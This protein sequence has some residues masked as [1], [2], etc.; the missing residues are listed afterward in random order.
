MWRWVAA[1]LLLLA[2]AV[3]VFRAPL[4][5]VLWPDMRVQRLLDEAGQALAQG[6]LSA[7]DGSG[8]RQRFEA[9]QALDSDRSEARDGL[10]RVAT[11]A[12]AQARDHAQA[13]RFE[14]ARQSLALARE[15]QVPRAAADAVADQLRRREAAEAGLDDLVRQAESARAGGDL[16]QA[17]TLY[18]RILVLQ[19]SH[20]L[21]L[22]GREDA[23]AD[24]LQQARASLAKGDLPDSYQTIARARD[25]DAGHADLPELQALL[26]RVIERHR[27]QADRALRRGKLEVALAG[28]RQVLSASPQDAVALQGVDR[29]AVAYAQQATRQAADFDFTQ[30]EA[31]LRSA[32]GLAPQA[33]AVKQA[34]QSLQ[35]ARQSRLRLAS[36]LPAAERKHRVEVLLVAMQQAGA[37]GDWLTPP[38]ESA[39]DKLRA[40]QALSPD[41]P[42]VKRAAARLVPTTQACFE[43]E[44]RANRVRR[45]RGCFDAWQALAPADGRLQ[46]S[47]RRL[48]LKWIAVGDEQLGSGR[49]EFAAQALHEASELDAGAPGLA[50]FARRVR[51]AQT[52]GN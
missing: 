37:R 36:S 23:L 21:A 14:Q 44:M 29:V 6:R 22:E 42:E 33:T 30:A 3:V 28:Y 18:Q 16:Q 51:N 38:G 7:A 13:D 26:G 12:L 9:A 15:L 49:V 27:L 31:S 1:L 4:A 47:R 10:A 24:L 17:L 40:A 5:N 19:P 43:D 46:E 11:D 8:A 2:L 32:R 35:R 48:S 41:V 50:E 25:Y 39:Y 34:E 45:A 20:T 52:G